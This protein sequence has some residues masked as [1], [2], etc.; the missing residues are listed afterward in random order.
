MLVFPEFGLTCK[1]EV[2]KKYQPEINTQ[3]YCNTELGDFLRIFNN[4]KTKQYR[5]VT[6]SVG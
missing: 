1:C 4:I 6:L 2:K 3:S 5:T